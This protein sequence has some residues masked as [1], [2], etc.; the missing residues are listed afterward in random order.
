MRRTCQL[1]LLLF[2]FFLQSISAAESPPHSYADAVKKAGPAVVNIYTVQQDEIMSDDDKDLN[3]PS[4]RRFRLGSGVIMD[5]NGY[6]LSNYHVVQQARIILVALS[7]GRKARAK[8]IGSDPETDLAVLQIPLKDLQPITFGNSED[9]RVGDVVLAI[10]NPFGLGQT[11]TQGIISAVGRNTIGINQLENYIQTDAAIN[12][13]NS[14]GAL[15]NT[16]GKLIGINV[17]IYSRSGGY[18]GVGFA[19]PVNVA[20]NIMRQIIK[21]GSVER[22]YIGVN[23]VTLTL[24]IAQQLKI[25]QSSGVVV[26][27]VLPNTPASEAGLKVKDVILRIN[28]ND[29]DS[30]KGFLNFVAQQEP[31]TNLLLHVIR[32]GK[33][34]HVNLKAAI[35]P[36]PPT[37][38]DRGR[39]P[40]PDDRGD[41]P[42]Q[43]A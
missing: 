15:V 37:I 23:V 1:G 2:I 14:G 11:V 26:T 29:V 18:Q 28:Q 20:L 40:S 22:G 6:V 43:V 9:I 42:D 24:N 34:I 35:R 4:K 16:Q 36:P 39:A 10:G 13:G 27:Q 7:D 12:P 17:G 41:L 30:A 5:Q 21:T 33:A 8:M 32:D 19:I 3:T 31:G 25:S 38:D